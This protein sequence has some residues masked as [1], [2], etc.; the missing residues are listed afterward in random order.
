MKINATLLEIGEKYLIRDFAMRSSDDLV[1]SQK[2]CREKRVSL[3]VYI[4]IPPLTLSVSPVIYE[5]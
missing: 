2:D 3:N 1:A 4:N 5:A